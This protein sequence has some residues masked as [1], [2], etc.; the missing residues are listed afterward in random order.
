MR[1]FFLHFLAFAVGAGALPAQ[2]QALKVQLPGAPTLYRAAT[3]A[4]IM[5]A[6]GLPLDSLPVA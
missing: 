3:L 6:A 4:T 5:E 2:Q 1:R